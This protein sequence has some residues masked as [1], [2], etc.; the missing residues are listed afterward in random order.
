MLSIFLFSEEGPQGGNP[1]CSSLPPVPPGHRQLWWRGHRV[2]RAFWAH[3]VP[4]CQPFSKWAATHWRWCQTLNVN[5]R[6]FSYSATRSL[7]FLTEQDSMQVLR[8]SYSLR[9]ASYSNSPWQRLWWRLG[10]WV[11]MMWIVEDF[12][13]FWQSTVSV[14]SLLRV[15]W[16]VE[17]AQWKQTCGQS[18]NCKM[19]KIITIVSLSLTWMSHNVLKDSHW[20][21][22]IG[23]GIFFLPIS[24]QVC[25]RFP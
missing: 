18:Q 4:L 23:A 11:S 7:Y 21:S 24:L 1:V 22:K 3:A 20:R 14:S 2:G 19:K 15:R 17:C 9:T 25:Y 13:S 12:H 8:A 5:N 6:Y 16:S 10:P